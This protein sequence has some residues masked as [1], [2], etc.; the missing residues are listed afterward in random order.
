M[1]RSTA[2]LCLLVSFAGCDPRCAEPPPPADAGPGAGAAVRVLKGGDGTGTIVSDPEGIDCE[3]DCDEQ[4]LELTE[5]TTTM[6]LV[7]EPARDALFE[8]WTCTSTK[9][10]EPQPQV[11]PLTD[12]EILAFDDA[13]PVGVDVECTARF[14]QLHTLLV[15]FAG[16][17]TG[18]VTGSAPAPEGGQRIDCPPKCTAGYF[19]DESDT[20][21]PVADEGSVFAGWQLDC[22]GTGDFTVTLDE[23]KNCEARFELE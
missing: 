8:S 21:T 19:A 13:D 4:L 5:E 17:G 18:R 7:A 10:G 12:L 9:N 23:D 2:M 14:R 1:T 20:L 11:G 15:I 22:E 3:V 6:T 16:Q